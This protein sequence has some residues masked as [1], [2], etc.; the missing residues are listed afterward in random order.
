MFGCARARGCCGSIPNARRLSAGA[1]ARVSAK[2]PPPP[3]CRRAVPSANFD[4]LQPSARKRNAHKTLWFR[5]A[6]AVRSARASH[7]TDELEV[8]VC[9]GFCCDS[10]EVLRVYLR[11][12]CEV[13]HYRV[14]FL[15]Q[16]DLLRVFF[17]LT[18]PDTYLI[19]YYLFV[20][21]LNSFPAS[22]R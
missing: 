9:F 11:L 7:L 15:F 1:C 14:F 6:C 13:C 19:I 2:P 12:F 20:I 22:H 18:H 3:L 21:Y 16:S 10:T 5:V 4:E 8:F 17:C